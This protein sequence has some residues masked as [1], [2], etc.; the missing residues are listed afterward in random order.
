MQ[1]EPT[2]GGTGR[3][4]FLLTGA[5]MAAA[6]MASVSA[7]IAAEPGTAAEPLIQAGDTMLFQGD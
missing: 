6:G 3:R 4:A 2:L 5:G 1:T 7:A